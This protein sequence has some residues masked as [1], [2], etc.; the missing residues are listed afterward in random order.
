MFL[1]FLEELHV[2][3]NYFG[4]EIPSEYSMLRNLSECVFAACVP[5]ATASLVFGRNFLGT[6]WFVCCIFSDYG[7]ESFS[8]LLGRLSLQILPCLVLPVLSLLCPFSSPTAH[9]RLSEFLSHL[10][11]CL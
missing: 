3:K 2:G 6:V 10:S 1:D 8:V 7:G 11:S 4:G 9:P 5:P